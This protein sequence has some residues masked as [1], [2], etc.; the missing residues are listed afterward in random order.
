MKANWK[1]WTQTSKKKPVS[2]CCICGGKEFVTFAGRPNA[3]CIKCNAL[4][5]TRMAALMLKKYNVLKQGMNILHFAPE[6]SLH[7]LIQSYSPSEYI[8]ADISTSVQGIEVTYFDIPKQIHTLPENHFDLILHNHVMEHL[9][10][11]DVF[12]AYHIHRALKPGGHHLFSF[13]IYPGRKYKCDFEETNP[14]ILEERYGQNDHVAMY[15]SEDFETG[16]GAC[17][18]IPNNYSIE[19]HLDK[20]SL[21]ENCIAQNFREGLNGSTVFLKRKEDWAFNM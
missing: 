8:K 18:N 12:V 5:R 13:P 19:D 10:C 15:G 16:F 6:K 3:R 21:D 2:I 9:R 17:L 1:L 4:E 20:K 14:K 7:D 11:S